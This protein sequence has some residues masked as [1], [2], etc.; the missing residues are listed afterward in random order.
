MRD[1]AIPHH[2]WPSPN[3]PAVPIS[4]SCSG[5]RLVVTVQPV[6]RTA[7]SDF[8]PQGTC[9]G[10]GSCQSAPRSSSRRRRRVALASAQ[11]NHATKLAASIGLK[12][13]SIIVT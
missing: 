11:T 7:G 12:S 4:G 9:F 10:A 6:L 2:S 8:G 13:L 3:P 5:L 1:A